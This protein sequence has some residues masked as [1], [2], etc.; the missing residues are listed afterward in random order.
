MNP[1][2][3]YPGSFSPPTYGHFSIVKQVAAFTPEIIIICSTN[4]EKS[5][6]FTEEESVEL[7]QAYKL[8]PNVRVLTFASFLAERIDPENII[9]VRG[10]RDSQDF[11]YEK[12]VAFLN[13]DNFGIDKFLYIMSNPENENVSSSAARKAAEEL[14]LTDLAKLV[15]PR[16]ATALLEK[17]LHVKN[18]ILVVGRPGSGKSTFLRQLTKFDPRNVHINTDDFNQQLRLLLQ[19]IFQETNLTKIALEREEEVKAAIAK[20][21][22]EMLS[23]SLRQVP[24][25]S[26]VFVEI[27]YAFKPG[28]DLYKILGGK[29]LYFDCGN[30]KENER[31]LKARGTPHLNPLIAT[32]PDWIETKRLADK[33]NLQIG[34]IDTTGT[35]A[36][37]K[38]KVEW[39]SNRLNQTTPLFPFP[40]YGDLEPGSQSV[41]YRRV[42][43]LS[44][45]NRGHLRKVGD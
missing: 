9:M 33:E 19:S 27:A 5:S 31:R 22:M 28:M 39:L 18:L 15:A 12:K 6:V 4:D 24:P 42:L 3:V 13:R 26:N 20:P 35:L 43:S 8:P 44:F 30:T 14:R 10:I 41:S 1:I 21:W 36:Q 11:D 17:T 7:W 37:M 29:T 32:I 16:V 38:K 40:I 2:F 25:D 34:L 23:Q 45:R